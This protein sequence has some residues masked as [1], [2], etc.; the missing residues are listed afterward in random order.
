MTFQIDAVRA[1]FPALGITDQGKRRIYLDNPAGTQVP[2]DGGRRRREMPAGDQRQSRRLLRDDAWPHRRWSTRRTRRWPISSAQATP[3]EVIIGANM[4]TLTYHMS[5]T[6]GRGFD[7]RRRDHRHA[8]G[9]R[10]QRLAVAAACRGPRADGAL[11]AVRHGSWQVEEDDLKKLL[12]ERTKL[13]ALNYASNLTGSINPV[14][15]LVRLAQGG[16]RAD[17]CRR[18]AVRPARAGRRRGSRLRFPRLLGLQILRAA[19]GH[20]VGTARGDRRAE[21]LQMPLLVQRPAGA[22]RAWHA[23]DRA[24]GRVCRRRSAISRAWARPR[25]RPAR[26]ATGLLRPSPPRSPT[27]RRW[28]SS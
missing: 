11:P 28:R 7:A 22:L 5:R 14:K 1:Q 13:V 8:H 19:Y 20:P 9:S 26:A 3:E 2:Q 23:A 4:T 21:A 16:R 12:N 10:G 27:R 17:L 18:G 15:R 25:V 24:D 6:L